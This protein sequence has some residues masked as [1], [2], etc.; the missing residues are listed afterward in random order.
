MEACARRCS[1][2]WQDVEGD[3]SW[4]SLLCSCSV[5]VVWGRGRGE[6]V[7]CGGSKEL[8]LES[9][10]AAFADPAC[11]ACLLACSVMMLKL[12]PLHVKER[13]VEQSSA[14]CGKTPASAHNM[15][16]LT[17][18]ETAAD[19]INGSGCCWVR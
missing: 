10:S 17:G 4:H 5:D 7:R 9:T 2:S 3:D 18:P 16:L 15:P 11:I 6:H 1:S 13:Y 14:F 12:R 8:L 19:I